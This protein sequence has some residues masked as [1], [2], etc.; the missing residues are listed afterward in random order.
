VLRTQ[1]ELARFDADQ[2]AVV[3]SER[4]LNRLGAVAGE[5]ARPGASFPSFVRAGAVDLAHTLR[6]LLAVLA[7]QRPRPPRKERSPRTWPRWR[8]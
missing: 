4:E 7:H 6:T 5:P 2:P 8:R 1:R 3:A